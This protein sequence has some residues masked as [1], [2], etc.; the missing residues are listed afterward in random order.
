MAIVNANKSFYEI[1]NK[2]LSNL[3]MLRLY[4]ILRDTL[5]SDKKSSEFLYDL[6]V[7]GVIS[8]D[9]QGRGKIFVAFSDDIIK[10]LRTWR[11]GEENEI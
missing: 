3:S 9:I 7:N 1:K 4:N 2:K 5:K 11:I 8:N 10:I 6:N